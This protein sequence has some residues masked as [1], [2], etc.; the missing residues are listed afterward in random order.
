MKNEYTMPMVETAV[1]VVTPSTTSARITKGSVCAG[2]AMMK[3]LSTVDL[4]WR[5]TL[6]RSSL[7]LRYQTTRH[8]IMPS[9]ALGTRPPMNNEVIDT[10]VTEPIVIS[11]RLGDR[12]STRL[13]SSH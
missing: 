2:K 13:N 11:T 7:R 6:L 9:T 3:L 4:V 5:T 1:A 12:K 10:L 8:S